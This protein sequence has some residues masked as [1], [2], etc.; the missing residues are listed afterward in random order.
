MKKIVR[1]TESDLIRLVKRVISEENSQYKKEYDNRIQ[2]LFR[3][4]GENK[5]CGDGNM[6]SVNK[7]DE[8]VKQY[9]IILNK[10]YG[11]PKVREDGKLGPETRNYACS[12]LT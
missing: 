9:Q 10:Y 5:I 7:Y 6:D 12:R 1:L 8:D 4:F 3:K 11:G 2:V